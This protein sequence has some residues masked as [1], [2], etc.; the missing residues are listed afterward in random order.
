M[1]TI[2]PQPYVG[3]GLLG[4]DERNNILG[5]FAGGLLQGFTV[6]P[7][8]VMGQYFTPIGGGTPTVT[9]GMQDQA[10]MLTP[11]EFA[12]MMQDYRNQQNLLNE[13]AAA[14]D[15]APSD[16]PFGPGGFG[17]AEA[18][19]PSMQVSSL[20]EALGN[21]YSGFTDA[22]GQKQA[23]FKDLIAEMPMGRLA[24]EIRGLLAG[25]D[26]SDGLFDDPDFYSDLA[27]DDVSLED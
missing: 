25:G 12:R 2:M 17:P 7:T 23:G 8:P 5:T 14:D 19:P 21:M 20:G 27:E 4:D 24:R 15:F 1:V 11:E 9:G 26:E 22:Q 18:E 6:N 10:T 16:G 13:G 3:Q